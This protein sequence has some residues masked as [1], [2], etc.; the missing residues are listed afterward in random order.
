MCCCAVAWSQ[1]SDAL[2]PQ[3]RARI[4]RLAGSRSQAKRFGLKAKRTD[5]GK[6]TVCTLHTAASSNTR[7][8]LQIFWDTTGMG[9]QDAVRTMTRAILEV[10]VLNKDTMGGQVKRLAVDKG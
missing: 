4:H 10:D 2:D 6:A 8:P 1:R 3:W 9:V 5:K 7:L